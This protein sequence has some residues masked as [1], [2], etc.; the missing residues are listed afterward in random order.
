MELFVYGTLTDS[1][2]AESVLDS[3]E[4]G[5]PATLSGL[6]R[7]EGA[8]PTL[9]PG[10]SVTGRLLE[11]DEVAALD[12][13]EGIDRGLYVRVSVPRETG[14]SVSTYVGNPEPLGVPDEWLGEGEFE[15]R[16]RDYLD[17][18]EVYVQIDK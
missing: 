2:T 14:D 9:L 13:Y 12:R 5:P 8:Y 10:G 11:T 4:Y 15:E 16:I 7:V 3:F 6:R 17:E 18:N 1:E